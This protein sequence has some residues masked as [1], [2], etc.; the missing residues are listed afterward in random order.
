MNTMAIITRPKIEGK[1]T[2]TLYAWQTSAYIELISNGRK[3]GGPEVRRPL[4]DNDIP[5]VNRDKIAQLVRENFPDAA[6]TANDCE[7]EE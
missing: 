7:E 3:A 4:S 6:V 5:H 2:R 1:I